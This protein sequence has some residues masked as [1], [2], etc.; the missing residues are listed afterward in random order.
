MSLVKIF[1]FKAWCNDAVELRSA[2]HL[3]HKADL[4]LLN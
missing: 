4:T 2:E 1:S 3:N